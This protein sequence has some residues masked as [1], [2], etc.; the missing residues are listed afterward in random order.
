MNDQIA[1]KKAVY[2]D[3]HPDLAI[4]LQP[5]GLSINR[6]IEVERKK[7]IDTAKSEYE[8]QL[9]Q[10]NALE[11]Q[12]RAVETQMLVDGQA[13]VK[14]QELQRDADA[15]KNIYE[16]FLS[17]F[18]TTNEQR[19]LQSSQTKIA[20][21]AI[22]PMRST[23]SAPRLVLAALAIG[24]IL[25]STA[26]VAAMGSMSDGPAPAEVLKLLLKLLRVLKRRRRKSSDRPRPRASPR[27]CRTCLSGP[28]FPIWRLAPW[29]TPLAKADHCDGR[30][31]SRRIS[32]SASRADRSRAGA[33]LQGRPRVVG[34]QRC[35]R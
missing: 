19:Q 13:L 15:N 32:A 27:R 18:K 8:A 20:S 28:A 29:P 1:Q 9:E 24:S 30:A 17:R 11:K 21:L 7:N 35:R 6:Q 3:R 5:A 22:P 4:L 33:W 16:Q 10:Q 12:L 31:R 25:T 34:R 2:G 23:Q 14:L 26:A